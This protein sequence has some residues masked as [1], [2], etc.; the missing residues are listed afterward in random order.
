MA[1]CKNRRRPLNTFISRSVFRA[2]CGLALAVLLY[3][4]VYWTRVALDLQAHAPP[5]AEHPYDW[6]AEGC[7]GGV[8]ILLA[9]IF[10]SR[11]TPRRWRKTA[12]RHAQNAG[13]S[14]AKTAKRRRGSGYNRLT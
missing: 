11:P 5:G 12:R 8:L 4:F 1:S 13:L 14:V 3:G 6:E 9:V 10:M 7:L 2:V